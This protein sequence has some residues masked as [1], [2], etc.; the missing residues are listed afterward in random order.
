MKNPIIRW[1]KDQGPLVLNHGITPTSDETYINDVD[2]FASVIW[3]VHNP[4]PPFIRK[5]APSSMVPMECRD[6]RQKTM[7]FEG[8][9]SIRGMG[10]YNYNIYIYRLEPRRC[11]RFRWYKTPDGKPL[12]AFGYEVF[13]V[14]RGIKQAIFPKDW[15]SIDLSI[16]MVV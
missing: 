5:T 11:F 14:F 6:S 16:S 1:E 9:F 4:I 10:L 13:A 8:V 2:S 12:N 15:Y 3:R 7:V